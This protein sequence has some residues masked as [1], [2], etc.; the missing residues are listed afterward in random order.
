MFHERSK[1]IDVK[2][3]YVRE[4]VAQGKLQVCKGCTHDNHVDMMIKSVHV[5]KFEH[6]SRLVGITV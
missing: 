6:F 3:Y 5:A 4:I 2:C 1:H